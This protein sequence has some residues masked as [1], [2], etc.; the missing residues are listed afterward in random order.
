MFAVALT[1]EPQ[2]KV[3][4][5]GGGEPPRLGLGNAGALGGGVSVAPASAVGVGE[6]LPVVAGEPV[7]AQSARI[8]DAR[9]AGLT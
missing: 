3:K 6:T 2:V 7:Q 4:D 1:R 8:A 9:T 5:I